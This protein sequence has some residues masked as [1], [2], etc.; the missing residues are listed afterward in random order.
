MAVVSQDW[1]YFTAIWC[2]FIWGN[3]PL[4]LLSYR[5]AV[6]V[7]WERAV[8]L[9]P[10]RG[11]IYL[12]AVLCSDCRRAAYLRECCDRVAYTYALVEDLGR[13]KPLRRLY[14]NTMYLN[15]PA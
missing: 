11:D 12:P 15:K 14:C 7:L 2:G 1:D 9:C 8:Y 3:T 10:E 4:P 5:W 13:V 6:A